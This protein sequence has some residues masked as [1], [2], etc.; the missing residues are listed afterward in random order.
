[1]TEAPN[2]PDERLGAVLQE[3]YG[4][5]PATL[6]FLPLGADSA[7]AVYRVETLAGKSYLLKLRAEGGFSPTSLTVPAFLQSRGLP[8]ILAPIPTL[9]GAL[10]VEIES[11]AVT[12]YPFIEGQ[13][14]ARLGLTTAQWR[15]FG[16]AVGGFHRLALPSEL[17]QTLPTE[18]FTPSRWS[19]LP[20]LEAAVTQGRFA[21]DLEREFA[22]F[23][24]AH[25]AEI[26]ALVEQ[27]EHLS[28]QLRKRPHSKVLCHADLHTWNLML[29][30]SRQPWIIDWDETILAPKERDL[31]FVVGGISRK[32]ITPAATEA[33]LEG[34]GVT[35]I[36]PLLLTYYRHAWAVQDIAAY[37]EQV[38][39]Q[40]GLS[41][42]SR[43]EGLQGLMRIFE[44]GEIV[45]I[46][47][48]SRA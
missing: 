25:R 35:E 42:A 17:S 9:D 15:Q 43:L 48:K 14:A 33:F 39:Y 41:E 19:H 13:S 46:A 11:F 16:A 6:T 23:W 2:V 1:M 4:I 3:R 26:R 40:A 8:A 12:L 34:Y 18:S 37:G 5:T 47:L 28:H 30:A 21:S 32:L 29:D 44:P 45:S 27:V 20:K 24:T 10:W 38:L 36:D 7:S 22:A 31:M